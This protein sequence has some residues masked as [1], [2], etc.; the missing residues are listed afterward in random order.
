MRH[1]QNKFTLRGHTGTLAGKP[2]LVVFPDPTDFTVGVVEDVKTGAPRPSDVAQVLLY[3]MSL[4]RC[5]P[6]YKNTKFAGRVIYKDHVVEI[7]AD[8][9]DATFMNNFKE[10]WTRLAS[11]DVAAK[12]PSATECR[13]CKL[14]SVDCP[15]R[16]E[17][18]ATTANTDLF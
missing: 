5:F 14:T 11:K 1:A 18:A 6:Q 17:A 4:H 10:L 13:F 3:M 12:I 2:D 8:R 7:P 9:L 15:E 16:V